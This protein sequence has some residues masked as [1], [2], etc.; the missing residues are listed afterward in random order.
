MNY[1]L[2]LKVIGNVLKYETLLLFIP[3]MVALYY[4]EDVDP[5]IY[6]Y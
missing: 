1:K 2:V 6:Q 4:G 5:F 3:F